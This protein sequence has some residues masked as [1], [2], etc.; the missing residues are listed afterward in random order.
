MPVPSSVTRK[1]S[2]RSVPP[3]RPEAAVAVAVPAVGAAAGAAVE[4]AE[5]QVRMMPVSTGSK[6]EDFIVLPLERRLLRLR[7]SA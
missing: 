3:A 6:R 2:V 1:W 7:R 5:A 4:S